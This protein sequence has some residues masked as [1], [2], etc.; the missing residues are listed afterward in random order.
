MRCGFHLMAGLA[1]AWAAAC[2]SARAE[3][4][5]DP[6]ELR[7]AA[8]Q[9]L[10]RGEFAWAHPEGVWLGEIV[11]PFDRWRTQIGWGGLA[12][13]KD[14][15]ELL[16]PKPWVWGPCASDGPPPAEGWVAWPVLAAMLR[17]RCQRETVGV[18][19]LPTGS[20]LAALPDTD[21]TIARFFDLQ[22]RI[23]HPVPA[24]QSPDVALAAEARA[25][26]EL[27]DSLRSA[28]HLWAALAAGLLLALT[29]LA[30]LLA[31]P[32]P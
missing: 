19:N 7:R 6:E 13:S 23:Y 8:E 5:E 26:H 4:P 22:K 25:A 15:L 12:A 2:P 10:L 17:E 14:T 29:L 28:S 9:H 3:P 1:V 16:P 30:G 31:R 20:P 32:R 24:E 21:G 27:A 11:S 18:E